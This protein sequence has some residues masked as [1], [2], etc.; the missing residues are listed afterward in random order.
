MSLEY[1]PG[2]VDPKILRKLQVNSA[3]ERAM[4]GVMF[5]IAL[6]YG[7]EAEAVSIDE[8]RSAIRYNLESARNRALQKVGVLDESFRVIPGQEEFLKR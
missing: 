7:T 5:T 4:I 6:E 8:N 2:N 1:D 3:V